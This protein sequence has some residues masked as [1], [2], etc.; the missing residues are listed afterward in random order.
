[1]WN[2]FHF[3]SLTLK[4]KFCCPTATHKLVSLPCSVLWTTDGWWSGDPCFGSQI[5]HFQS[6]I[7]NTEQMRLQLKKKNTIKRNIIWKL[8]HAHLLRDTSCTGSIQVIDVEPWRVDNVLNCIELKS[9]GR[10]RKDAISK[11]YRTLYASQTIRIAQFNVQKRSSS[12]PGYCR[13][14]T[15]HLCSK[16]SAGHSTSYTRTHT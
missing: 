5:G 11:E 9:D 6:W 2:S 1:M 13:S 16:M 14:H 3:E 7:Q 8:L 12:H 10:I 4:E 15:L